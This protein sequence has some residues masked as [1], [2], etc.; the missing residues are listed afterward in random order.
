MGET[1][2]Q[3][4]RH[5][6]ETRN[7]LG[8]N[9]SEL[10]AKVK[11]AIDWRAQFDE[12]P[13]TMIAVAF[14]GGVLLSAMLPSAHSSRKK[15]TDRRWMSSPD[16]GA[17]SSLKPP[18]DQHGRTAETIEALKGALVGAALTKFSGFIDELLPGFKQ[19][20]AKTRVGGSLER[21][22]SSSAELSARQDTAVGHA[23]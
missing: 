8:D 11:T 7:N 13:M 15:Y 17:V 19:E 14:G 4:E 6:Q 2:N 18:A 21:S 5:I 22:N 1:S 23:D 3:I 16:R 12:H 10:N 20:F 9:F